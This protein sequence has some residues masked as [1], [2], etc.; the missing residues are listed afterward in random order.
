MA[1]R[2]MTGNTLNAGSPPNPRSGIGGEAQRGMGTFTRRPGTKP[3]HGPYELTESAFT[4]GTDVAQKARLYEESV[5]YKNLANDQFVAEQAKAAVLSGIKDVFNVMEFLRN[6]WLI[7]YRL[8]RGESLDTFT[9]GRNRLHSPEP[10]KIVETLHPKMMRTIFGSERFFKLYG[11]HHEHDDSAKMQEV[12]CRSQLRTNRYRSKASRFIR[13]G[14]IYGTAIQ[15]SYWRQELDEMTYRTAQSIPNPEFPGTSK[16][17]LSKK[18]RQELIFDGNEINNV[19]IFDFLTAPNASS[20]EDA[21]WC[22]DRSGWPDFKVKSMGELGHWLNLQKLKDHAGSRD[23]SFGDEFKERKSYSYGVFD[24]REAS[25]APHVPHYEVIDWWGPLVVKAE[26]GGYTTKMC[27][28]V[29]IEPK[30]LQLIV[31]VTENPFWHKKKPYQVWRPISLEDELYG[32]GSLEMIARLSMEKD[33]KR[34]LLMAATQLESNPMWLISDDANIP[35]GQLLLEPGLGIRVPDIANAIAPL[36]MPTVSDSAL[37]AENVLTM[38]IRE[39]A[40]ATSPSMGAQDPFGKNKTATQHTSEIDEAN[41]RLVPMIE[42]YEAEV[43]EPMLNQMTWNNQQF[44][45]YP[46]VVREVGALGLQFN[47]RFT[48]RPE[49]ILGRFLV[50]CLS[51]HK[52]TTKQTQ[53]QQ[54]VN[55]LDRAPIIN[56]M[57]GPQAVK[58]PKLL[59]LILEQ[60]FDIRNVDEIISIPNE[61]SIITP[62][63]EHLLWYHGNVPPRRID[64]NDMRHVT[65]HMEEIASET[66]AKLEQHSPG[67][68]ARARAHVAE[69]YRKLELLQLQ[70][71][72]MMMQMSQVG[73]QMGLLQGGGGGSSPIG[74]AGGPGQDPG[75]P[76]VRNN[77]TERGEGSAVK[78]AA[79]R[80]APNAG[81]V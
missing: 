66:F 41:L 23:I 57:Y 6:K 52:L 37:K 34:N 69:H 80:E 55:I 44:M 2:G 20:I 73:N 79:G 45:S 61:S 36:H 56:Q 12:L 3:V 70:Q 26:G 18:T 27:N 19:S 21:E 78:S 30:S 63:E 16:K 7:L 22:A 49:D 33:M 62:T 42:A 47:D 71:E 11:E 39:T 77:E 40:G 72:D 4:D 74:G 14:L 10:Y 50:Q 38:D 54:L 28:V 68:A 15:K 24:P 64:D 58:M 13:D 46:R 75:S 5:G 53:V 81:A 35:A 65:A 60:G 31:R 59:A 25:W 8:Y 48:I 43:Q 29:M 76:K 1:D 32:I 9:Y 17:K 67:T 51:S